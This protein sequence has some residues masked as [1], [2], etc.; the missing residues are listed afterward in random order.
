MQRVLPLSSRSEDCPARISPGP[1]KVD[2]DAEWVQ[3][4]KDGRHKGTHMHTSRTND[5]FGVRVAVVL[6][7]HEMTLSIYT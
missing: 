3:G 7:D 4:C 5:I 1:D 2:L 6:A